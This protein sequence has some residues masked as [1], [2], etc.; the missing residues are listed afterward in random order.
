MIY[1]TYKQLLVL[2]PTLSIADFHPITGTIRLQDDSDG[3][4]AHI[5][6]WNHSTLTMPTLAQTSILPKI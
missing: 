3:K 4:G 5:V 1:A 2:Y 6:Q